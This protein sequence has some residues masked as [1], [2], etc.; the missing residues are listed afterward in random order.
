MKNKLLNQLIAVLFLFVWAGQWSPV[1]GREAPV[2][3]LKQ[4]SGPVYCLYGKGGNIGVLKTGDGLLLVDSQFR[5]TA[6]KALKAIAGLSDKP[7]KFLV[8][9]HYHGD[10]TGG[11]PVLGK[12]AVMVMHPQC[13]ASVKKSLQKKKDADAGYL[14]K[15]SDWKEG[16]TITLGKETIKLLHFGNGHT[17]G[18]LVVVFETSKVVHVGDLFFNNIAPYIDVK[19]GSDTG[20][21]VRTIKTICKKYPDFKIVPGHG[22]VTDTAGYIKF[23]HYL[24]LLR[25]QV[26]S[27]VKVGKSRQWVMD[28]ATFEGYEKLTEYGS[29]M[30]KKNNVGWIYDEMTRNK[31]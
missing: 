12:G 31:K 10:H 23:A 16:K 25:K 17:S 6:P 8:N 5:D 30:T 4:V 11:T 18:D 26:A 29:F 2:F 13:K 20:N 27:A 21:W 24:T 15:V 9:T 19:D 28:S 22:K 1:I 7:V 3:E 14:E